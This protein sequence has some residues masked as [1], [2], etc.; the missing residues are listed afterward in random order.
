[1]VIA[2]NLNEKTKNN[3]EHEKISL[4]GGNRLGIR[5]LGGATQRCERPRSLTS[6]P[7]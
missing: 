4:Y 1:M 3:D 7:I 5:S 2:G 6:T